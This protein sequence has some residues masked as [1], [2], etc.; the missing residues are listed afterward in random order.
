MRSR[1]L[2]AFIAVLLLTFLLPWAQELQ[3][4]NEVS[5]REWEVPWDNT[6]PRDP[7]VDPEGKVW[8][9]GQRGD[10]LG[11]LDPASGEFRRYE[12]SPGTG[13]HNLIVDDQGFVWYAGNRDRHVGRLDPETGEIVRY[14][15]TDPDA[16][17]PHTLV[18]DGRGHIWFTVQGGNFVGRL[19]MS[20]GA[21][22]LWPVPTERARPYGIVIDSEGR[23]W[24]AAFGTYKLVTIDPETEELTEIDLPRT[25]ARPRRIAL[26]SDDVVWYGDYAGGM[27][28]RYDPTSGEFTEWPLPAG[29]SARPYAMTSDSQDRVWIAETGPSPNRLV[30]FDPE[31]EE[32]FS[33]TEIPSGGGTLRHMI[34]HRPTRTIWFGADS[35]TVGRVS[36]LLN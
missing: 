2:P 22:R 34:F 27:L 18:F 23:P 16:R 25:E 29:E 8:F 36:D 11:V 3:A 32:F 6:R 35:N 24:V 13:P 30:G 17:D 21:M 4:Q 28:G 20:D 26:T 9:C 31:S 5:I 7:Y 14:E 12:L 19:R 1:F 10:Y 15:M 33:V